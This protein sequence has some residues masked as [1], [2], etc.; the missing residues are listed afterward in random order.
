MHV[1]KNQLRHAHKSNKDDMTTKVLILPLT[2]FGMIE[3][4]TTDD[5]SRQ[6]SLRELGKT[7]K[8]YLTLRQEMELLCSW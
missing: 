2:S 5:C 7:G 1:V 4:G 6:R 3:F 8:R